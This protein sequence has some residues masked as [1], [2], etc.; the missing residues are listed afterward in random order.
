MGRPSPSR[1]LDSNSVSER[2]ATSSPR[3]CFEPRWVQ[4]DQTFTIDPDEETGYSG[5]GRVRDNCFRRSRRNGNGLS[6]DKVFG[7]MSARELL[8]EGR[9]GLTEYAL[10]HEDNMLSLLRNI[11]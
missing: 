6:D 8:R 2:G 7:T 10:V 11:Y 4:N 5:A 9:G 1:Q 3:S